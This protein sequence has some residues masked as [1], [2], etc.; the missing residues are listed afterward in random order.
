MGQT[1]PPFATNW[2]PRAGTGG[3]AHGNQGPPLWD[4][5]VVCFA[6]PLPHRHKAAEQQG[7]DKKLFSDI[8]IGTFLCGT[9]QYPD[10]TVIEGSYRY[11]KADYPTVC[12][13]PPP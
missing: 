5:D 2:A 10:K 11:H 3:V 7:Q 12:Q 6:T 9:M 13:T 8:A 1:R 4:A